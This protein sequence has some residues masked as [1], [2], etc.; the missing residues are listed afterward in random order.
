MKMEFIWWQLLQ[1]E[2][3]LSIMDLFKEKHLRKQVCF[4]I[5]PTSCEEMQERCTEIK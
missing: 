3:G 2:Y 1:T 5:N 4:F